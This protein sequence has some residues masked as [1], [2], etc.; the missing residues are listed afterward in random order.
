MVYRGQFVE[1][2][3]NGQGVVRTSTGTYDGKFE[4]DEFNGKGCF[5]WEN[6]KKAYIGN[7]EKNKMHGDGKIIYQTGQVVEGKW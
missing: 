7:F 3:K 2:R 6:K 5:L 1:N 4:N